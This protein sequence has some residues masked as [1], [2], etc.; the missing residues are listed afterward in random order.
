MAN[1]G[2]LV[3][4]DMGARGIWG[5]EYIEDS[6]RVFRTYGTWAFVGVKQLE[7]LFRLFGWRG[8]LE[9]PPLLLLSREQVQRHQYP[10]ISDEEFVEF[11]SH[12]MKVIHGEEAINHW[13]GRGD[14]TRGNELGAVEL[15][16]SWRSERDHPEEIRAGWT[17]W[18]KRNKKEVA[19][20][21]ILV[22]PLPAIWY[23]ITN[24]Q[25]GMVLW[26]WW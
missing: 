20:V 10:P 16:M 13:E 26:R 3:F 2:Q 14:V 17:F 15:S 1:L 5:W 6:I 8:R 12:E 11:L 4:D 25:Y 23:E 22:L 19:T 18:G 9:T 24:L 21:L 7:S